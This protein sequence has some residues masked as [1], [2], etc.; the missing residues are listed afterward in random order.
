MKPDPRT[1][2]LLREIADAGVAEVFVLYRSKNGWG[3]C[4]DVDDLPNA[5]FEL[6]TAAIQA[7]LDIEPEDE[8]TRGRA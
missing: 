4:Y 7:R 2:L 1:A 8:P 3:Y 5:L 6:R